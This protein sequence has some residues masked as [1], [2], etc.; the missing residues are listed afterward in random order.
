MTRPF[1]H[2]CP[3][4]GESGVCPAVIAYEADVKHDGRLHHIQIPCLSVIQCTECREVYFVA[5]TDCQISQALREALVLLSP[6]EIRDRLASLGLTRREFAGQIQVAEE[7]ILGWL[8]GIHIQSSAS[9]ASMRMF[10]EREEA[11]RATINRFPA[12]KEWYEE[13]NP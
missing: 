2:P 9:D 13:E 7:T 8:S 11:R 6:Q 1:P 4:C 12:P 5:E 10:F 3:E